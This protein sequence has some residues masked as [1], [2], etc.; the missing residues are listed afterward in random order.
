MNDRELE[1]RMRDAF[2]ALEP[3]DAV[4]QR[5]LETYDVLA[6]GQAESKPGISLVASKPAARSRAARKARRS[7]FITA[8]AACLVLG[9]AVFGIFRVGGAPDA[10]VETTP[11][12]QSAVAPLDMVATAFVDIDIN[13][14]I[15]LQL[16]ASDQVVVANAMNDDGRAVIASLDLEGLPYEEA[17]AKLTKSEALAPY[18]SGDAYVQVSVSSDNQQ[19]EQALMSMSEQQLAA[20]PCRGS[21]D[22]VSLELHEE[23]HAH[24]MGC[25]RYIAAVELSTLDPNVTVDDCRGMSMREIRNRIDA[26][27]DRASSSSYGGGASQGGSASGYGDGYG[28]HHG[29]SHGRHH[30]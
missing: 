22:A 15:E 8:L 3:P 24:G 27:H 10:S 6:A 16:N 26:C 19:Q 17:F 7:R 25:G 21:C 14:S 29:E 18:L 11:G 9:V 12:D 1:T 13:P 4:K 28:Q 23:A 30:S 5:T 20:L 2:N